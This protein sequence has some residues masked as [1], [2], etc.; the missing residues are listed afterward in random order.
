MQKVIPLIISLMLLMPAFALD[1]SEWVEIYAPAVAQTEEGLVGAL[2]TMRIKIENGDGHVFV[3][4]FP[5]T[6]MDMQS[7]ARMAASVA[8]SV[9]DKNINDYDFFVVVRGDSQLVGGTSAGGAMT[10]AMIAALKNLTLR[11]GVMMTGTISP[12]G[13]IGPVSGIPQKMEAAKSVGTKTFLIP[14]G[15]ANYTYMETTSRQIGPLVITNQ[16][17]IETDLLDYG[18]NMGISVKEVSNVR[19]A[20]EEF[21][22]VKLE[23][24][25]STAIDTQEYARIM[26]SQAEKLEKDARN[27]YTKAQAVSSPELRNYTNES[28]KRIRNGLNFMSQGRYYTA[29][30]SFFESMIYSSYVV[31]YRNFSSDPEGAL[32]SV[33][34]G[35]EKTDGEIKNGTM[36]YNVL[37]IQCS[38]AAEEKMIEAKNSFE[39]AYNMT[40]NGS[41]ADFVFELCYAM[42][43]AKSAEWWLEV[44]RSVQAEATTL[45]EEY[46]SSMALSAM[47]TAQESLIYAQFSAS[48]EL[49]PVLLEANSLL[50]EAKAATKNGYTAGSIVLASKAQ[51]L[52]DLV[53]ELGARGADESSVNLTRENAMSAIARTQSSGVEPILALAYYEYAES[54]EGID[55]LQAMMNYKYAESIARMSGVA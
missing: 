18:K 6:E 42:E 13:S 41:I 27:S 26:K 21:T 12:D 39:R 34:T 36:L 11:K 5:L 20:V 3:D 52:S 19:E 8:C 22:G 25:E 35:L 2:S 16:K 10:V 29:S 46:V 1:T 47:N 43:R 15:Q 53:T 23:Q 31:N 44:S 48:S 17:P 37:Y 40:Q 30:S 32:K 54:Y 9:S 7:S 14:R 50:D 4:T 45:S 38:G 49:A 55:T 28:Y 33:G 24:I 51:A